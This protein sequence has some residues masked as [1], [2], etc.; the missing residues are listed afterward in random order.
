MVFQDILLIN[1]SMKEN[2]QLRENSRHDEYSE[3]RQEFKA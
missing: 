2:Q 3:P 1:G